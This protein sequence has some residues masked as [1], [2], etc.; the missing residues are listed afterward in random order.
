VG[1]QMVNCL[2]NY[3]GLRQEAR[4]AAVPI[5]Y[6]RS[7]REWHV[8][9]SFSVPALLCG[10]MVGPLNWLC[11]TVLINRPGGYAEMGLFNAANQWFGALLFLPGILGQAALPVLSDCLGQNDTEKSARVL[12]FYIKLNAMIVVPLVL[13]GSLVS[14]YLMASYGKGFQQGWPTLI[15]VLATAGL[16]AVL[17]TVGQVLVASGRLWV[18]AFMNLG[19]G[20]AYL[21][22]TLL[23]VSHGAFGLASARLLAYVVHAIWT[24]GFAVCIIKTSRK[25]SEVG[26]EA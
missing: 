23:L 18:G 3:H 9:W 14:P 2:L 11:N 8:L 15:V 4:H 12:G 10:L 1:S 17:S 16:L 7:S 25:H 5:T 19:W 6:A 20:A 24:F 26:Y 21:S 13:L 22:F